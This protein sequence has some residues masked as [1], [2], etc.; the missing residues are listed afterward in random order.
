MCNSC[1]TQYMRS[2]ELISIQPMT[3]PTGEIFSMRAKFVT[4]FVKAQPI[5][6]STHASRGRGTWALRLKRGLRCPARFNKGDL[7]DAK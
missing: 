1:Y 3:G 7:N 4:E 6:G 2:Y 5:E